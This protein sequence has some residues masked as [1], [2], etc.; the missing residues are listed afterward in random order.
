[1]NYEQNDDQYKR[2]FDVKWA[3]NEKPIRYGFH[4]VVSSIPEGYKVRVFHPD[5]KV[6]TEEKIYTT[7]ALTLLHGSFKS[8]WDDGS[9]RAQGI[10]Q[11][12][13]K[14]GSWLE[15]EPGKGK[16]SAGPYLNDKKEG[17]WTQL[18][19]SGLVESVYTWQDG[20]RHGKFF[21]YDTTGHK[22]NEGI[23]RA[24]TLVSELFKRSRTEKPYLVICR[25]A[26]A[27]EVY[28]CSQSTLVQRIYSQLRYPAEAR[29][30]KIE[31]S[32]LVQWDVMPDGRVQHIRVPQALS[33]EIEAEC[34]RVLKD[35]P[36]WEPA[37]RDGIPIKWTMSIPI[38][39]KQ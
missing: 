13:R 38:N 6:L 4:Y 20:L 25:N 9:I 17:I 3:A 35:M 39:F 22:S 21:E 29:Q 14:H 2:K 32:V 5:K 34:L 30:M 19:T 15:C 16:S 7:P 27:K 12:G 28:A 33:N 26:Y 36:L 23:Y 11:F 24:D 31:G 8:F 18:D 37:R 1:M 10:Y